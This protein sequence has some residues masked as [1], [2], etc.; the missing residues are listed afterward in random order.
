TTKA[1][2]IIPSKVAAAETEADR[3]ARVEP[4][5]KAQPGITRVVSRIITSVGIGRVTR[6]DDR[7][8]ADRIDRGRGVVGGR[9]L[10]GRWLGHGS[11]GGGSRRGRRGLG[12]RGR[13]GG[14]L[15]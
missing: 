7:R 15:A 14:A 6:I 9:R 8:R 3:N 10:H 1:G 12:L 4:T 11:R 2:A 5:V 13:L